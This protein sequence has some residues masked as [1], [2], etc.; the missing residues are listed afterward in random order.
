MSQRACNGVE[1]THTKIKFSNSCWVT[2]SISESPISR[3]ISYTP[4]KSGGNSNASSKIRSNSDGYTPRSNES[5]IPS[6]T[7]STSPFS[8]V[9]ILGSSP[10]I[11]CRM[12]SKRTLWDIA[13]NNRYS[14]SSINNRDNRWGI[15]VRSWCIHGTPDSA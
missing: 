10:N 14:T 1:M 5:G 11:V 15:L 8:V 13:S 3:L 4:I 2:P 12:D 7:S 9:E 6:T